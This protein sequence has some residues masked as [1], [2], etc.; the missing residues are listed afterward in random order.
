MSSSTCCHPPIIVT[1]IKEIFME[2]VFCAR[3]CVKYLKHNGTSYTPGV[4]FLIDTRI[5]LIIATL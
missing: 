2:Y 4:Y 1:S 5:W 3:Q